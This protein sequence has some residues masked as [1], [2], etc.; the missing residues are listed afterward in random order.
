MESQL[1]DSPERP[2]PQPPQPPQPQ[3]SRAQ[4]PMIYVYETQVWEYKT[5]VRKLADERL[6]SDEELNALGRDGWELAAAVTLASQVE[7]YFKRVRK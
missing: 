6:L 7:F 4:A 5:I 1:A 3:T 2:F